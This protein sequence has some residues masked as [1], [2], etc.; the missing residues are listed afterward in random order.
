M[1]LE[2]VVPYEQT[3]DA[4]MGMEILEAGEELGR[5]QV[6]VR[7]ALR[8]PMGPV[9]GGVFA[10]MAESLAS[11]AT[12][13]AVA[14]DGGAALGMSNHTSYVRP[15]TDGTVHAVARRRHRGRTTWVW[16]VEITDDDDRLCALSR[17]TV[18]VR[19]RD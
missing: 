14:G 16:E 12:G 6:G 3:F 10:A 4:L 8:Q 9:H 2:L 13:L 19:R 7:D 15:I 5:A 11:I 17:V 18:A 1:E